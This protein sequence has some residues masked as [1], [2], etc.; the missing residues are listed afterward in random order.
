MNDRTF[1]KKVSLA[2]DEYGE[3]KNYWLDK[4]AGELI[5]TTFP[6]DFYSPEIKELGKVEIEKTAA[7]EM[8][9]PTGLCSKLLKI[10]KKSDYTLHMILVAGVVVLLNKY[11][12]ADDIM[13]GMPIYR[14]SKEGEFLNTVMVLR[15]KLQTSMNFKEL[16]LQVRQTIMEANENQNY[17]IEVLLTQLKQSFS[18]NEN[19]F[20]LF[21]IA[22][23]LENIHDRSYLQHIQTN[24]IFSFLRTGEY[25]GG[26]LEFNPL[27][28]GIPT[29]ERII[30]HFKHLLQ[31]ALSNPTIL[32]SDMD[33]LSAEEKKR[34]LFDFNETKTPYPKDKTIHELFEQQVE[35]TP[36]NIA[37]VGMETGVETR[38]IVSV[39][40]RELNKKSNRL[41][42]LL[43][44]K[45]V[46]PDTIVGIMVE[47]SMEMMVG[48]L[49][50]LKAGGAYLPIDPDYPMERIAY[51]LL[52]SRANILV[53]TSS[54]AKE[55][56]NYTLRSWE[57]KRNHP[58]VLLDSF[59]FVNFSPSH[60]LTVSS[61]NP[62]SLVYIIYTS[63]TTGKPKGNLTTHFNVVRV[64]K[65]TN[66]IQLKESDRM[67]QLSNY[68]FDGSVFDI[69]GAF[70]NG[71]A[72]VLIEREKVLAVDQLA[73]LIK[74]E[75]ITVFFVTTALFNALVELKVDCLANIRKVLFGGERISIKH[76]RKALAYLGKGR[77]IHVYGPTET[78]V[79]A[80]YYFID[81]IAETS[82][83]I[84]IGRALANTTVYILEKELKP[85]PIGIHGEVYIGGDGVSHGYLNKPQLTW[86]KFISSLFIGG[87]RLY[88]TGDLA[89]WLP[90]GTIE[91][92]GRLDFQ[93]KVRGYR[94]EPAE[95]EKHLVDGQ[96]I[97]EAVI[98]ARE[99]GAGEKYLCA[100]LVPGKS[101]ISTEHRDGGPVAKEIDI[102]ELRRELS[103]KLPDY[104]IP[105][106]FV[107]VAKIPL[108]VNGKVDRKALSQTEAASAADKYT[109]PRNEVEKK[110]IEIW[111]DILDV[112]K[113]IIGIDTNFFELGGHSLNA[114]ILVYR[115]HKEFNVKVPM[116][117][118][119]RIPFIRELAEYIKGKTE[120]IYS[121]I[122]NVEEKEY[123]P[124]SSAQK[125]LYTMHQ[126]GLC[127]TNYNIPMAVI[128]E[129]NIDITL[130]EETFQQ[131]IQRH[132]S[133][134]TGFEYINRIP[135]QKIHDNVEF[136]I[137]WLAPATSLATFARPFNL[138]HP[139]LIRVGLSRLEAN[140]Y[141]LMV[142]MHHIITDGTSLGIFLKD[143][144]ACYECKELPGLRVQYKD[145]SH[146]QNHLVDSGEI[147]TQQEYWLNI[148]SGELPVL[149]LPLDY[150]RPVVQD[151]TGNKCSFTIESQQEEALREI[152]REEDVTP[153]MLYLALYSILI[154]RLSGQ[155]D[156]IV[157]TSVA[158]RRHADLENIMGMFVNMLP[159]RSFPKQEKTF[160]DFLREVK[161][162]A[163]EAFENQ[164][165]QF[166]A[167]IEQ[168]GIKRDVRRNPLFD[169]VF[170]MLNMD[171]PVIETAN[172]VLK[173][174]E[175]NNNIAKFDLLLIAEQKEDKILFT[176]YYCTELF[177]KKTIKRFIN[178][179]K[180]L[181]TIVIKEKNIQLKEIKLSQRL[182]TSKI[183]I[184]ADEYMNFGF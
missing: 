162:R 134:R 21:D 94:V 118:I 15:N 123:Y 126:T 135:V 163:L 77:I 155:E 91:F 35:K 145:F 16:L 106:Y 76:A 67:L 179:F 42:H 138:A 55:V 40:Y 152:A 3:E 70:L 125:R 47:R 97:K 133:F 8:K 78:T 86:E 57:G 23:L 89:C 31:A 116:A 95:I 140:K 43:R 24:M 168:M 54:L 172:L 175:N 174:Q 34:L 115:L 157:G 180:E 156:I 112:K 137:E 82:A 104:M 178:Y 81:H 20:P 154:S 111:A 75:Q 90:D 4:L 29:V 1:S 114:T 28:Y 130:L 100:Y 39:S 96:L 17:P 69:Y 92:L 182:L 22:I 108:T 50:I 139:P 84:P 85:V 66:Y 136:K 128:M 99:D 45:G 176:F 80:T 88:R 124:L 7:V 184:N 56:D 6:Y 68:A 38:F 19:E 122:K 11:T 44:K 167:L 30:A 46:E 87:D 127:P 5:K 53:T 41:A 164:D 143:F 26:K 33:L 98:I 166:E 141:L 62:S 177:K 101:E 129:G 142:D 121:M 132:A 61:S 64:V 159:L 71:A 27:L 146:W 48:I 170:V 13:V 79:F 120:N 74:R 160:K 107:Q 65:D 25:I 119:F 158:G 51:M 14:Q 83:T 113:D 183:N 110:I 103:K 63:G 169:V 153:F 117:E 109:S 32:I 171:I 18:S 73:E 151:F 131:L 147:K 12:R 49:G 148:L 58:I 2:A 149:D 37:V 60:R 59:E 105:A 10:S 9:F 93:V 165:Y 173:P 36:D 161:N 150:S 144:I 72:L 52:D 181:A 102:T